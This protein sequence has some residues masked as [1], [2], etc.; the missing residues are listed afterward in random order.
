MKIAVLFLGNPIFKDDAVGIEVGRRLIEKLEKMSMDV[1]ILER[2]GLS[3]LDFIPDYNMIII[4]DSI[5]SNKHSVGEV[6][7]IPGDLI[8]SMP[9]FSPHYAGIPEALMAIQ[10]L[11]LVNPKLIHLIA[12]ETKDPYTLGDSFSPEVSE[13]LESITNNVFNI[14]MKLTGRGEYEECNPI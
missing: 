3:L 6:Y 7:E 5:K 4:V 10:A 1:H 11:E 12:I 14:I 8:N 2:T 9:I 13:K